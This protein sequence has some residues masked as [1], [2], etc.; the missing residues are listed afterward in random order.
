MMRFMLWTGA[1]SAL[2]SLVAFPV[3]WRAVVL[4]LALSWAVWRTEVAMRRVPG[5]RRVTIFL[6]YGVLAGLMA[7][8]G[9]LA[10]M[11]VPGH[12]SHEML[13]WINAPLYA[14]PVI[15]TLYVLGIGWC[16][17]NRGKVS[18]W[19]L[20]V[21]ALLLASW[22][23][24]GFEFDEAVGVLVCFVLGAVPFAL[25][26]LLGAHLGREQPAKATSQTDNPVNP[27]NPV[28]STTGETGQ[29]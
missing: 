10:G 14:L 29:D 15:T 27:V 12:N 1:M 6:V 8:A 21:V 5:R 3:M 13:L 4:G 20:M 16:H 28:A 26:W 25:L 24:L 18:S 11:D 19:L 17:Q 2:S 9:V 22:L 23:R 7:G